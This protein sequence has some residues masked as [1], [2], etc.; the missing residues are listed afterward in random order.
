MSS[1]DET[2]ARRRGPLSPGAQQ[3]R[4]RTTVRAV[5]AVAGLLVLATAVQLGRAAGTGAVLALLGVVAATGVIAALLLGSDRR[6][7]TAAA[8]ADPALRADPP[9]DVERVRAQRAQ[10]GPVAAAREVRRQA[11]WLTLAEAAAIVDRL[12]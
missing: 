5:V 12:G 9:L 6:R 11:P 3:R 7:R 2:P 8:P 1:T 4:R 10:G